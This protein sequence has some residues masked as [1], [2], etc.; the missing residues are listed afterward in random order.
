MKVADANA[1]KERLN[2]NFITARNHMI[3]LR[4]KG[5]INLSNRPK[6]IGKFV[7]EESS[8]LLKQK[9]HDKVFNKLL[10]KFKTYVQASAFL[11]V[12]NS[13]LSTWKVRK[14]RIPLCHL[15][16]ICKILDIL[17]EEIYNN[18]EETDR[19]IAEII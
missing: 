19:E 1:V 14:I 18:V 5:K 3:V 4:D 11:E 12:S 6:V 17:P 16:N 15:K 10:E 13:R 7:S 9:T 2:C 8:V